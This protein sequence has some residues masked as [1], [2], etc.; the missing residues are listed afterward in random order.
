MI[1]LSPGYLHSSFKLLE[2]IARRDHKL[3]NLSESLGRIEILRASEVVNFAL[4]IGWIATDELGT[5]KLST[6]GARVYSLAITSERFRQAILDFVG[7]GQPAWSQ[8]IPR[9]RSETLSTLSPAVWQCFAEAELIASYSDEVVRWWD[10]LAAR[11]RGQRSEML[12][13]I[14]RRGEKLSLQ[15][16]R[17]RTG[18]IPQWQSVESN[19][20]GYDI[21]SVV[22]SHDTRQLQIEV[23]ATQADVGSSVF[24]LTRNEWDTGLLADQYVYH[25]WA[26]NQEPPALAVLDKSDL[27]RHVPTDEGAGLWELVEIPFAI[28]EPN[29]TEITSLR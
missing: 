10:A 29:F 13:E 9:G 17:K 11:A 15:Y 14:G 4:G 21:L 18:R 3:L 20:S 27:A 1:V 8:L 22:S 19:L 12:L 16:E 24:H 5:A 25:L 28:F 7:V 6:S 2:I 23:K 26:A